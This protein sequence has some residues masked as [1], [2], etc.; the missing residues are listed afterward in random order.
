M[1]TTWIDVLVEET[2]RDI[3]NTGIANIQEAVAKV[4]QFV[5][6]HPERKEYVLDA[7]ATVYGTY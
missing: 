3:L 7:L 4:E 1:P 6:K 2:K 5:A